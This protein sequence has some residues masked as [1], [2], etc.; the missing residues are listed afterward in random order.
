MFWK[1][2]KKKNNCCLFAAITLVCCFF[3]FTMYY[4]VQQYWSNLKKEVWN[5]FIVSEGI[6]I[7]LG[8]NNASLEEIREKCRKIGRMHYEAGIRFTTAQWKQARDLLIWCVSAPPSKLVFK[9]SQT[10]YI[11]FFFC[12][13]FIVSSKKMKIK[14][15][16]V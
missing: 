16:K 10:T 6:L 8:T 11:F 7:S 2:L 12:T 14:N 1:I 5:W 4:T 3:F 9:F 15:K 13:Y